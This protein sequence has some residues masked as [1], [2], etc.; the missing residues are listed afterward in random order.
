[1]EI[2]SMNRTPITIIVLGLAVVATWNLAQSVGR[3]PDGAASSTAGARI[4]VVDFVRVFNEAVQIRDLNEAIRQMTDD[5]TAEADQRRKA[6][7][8]KQLQLSAFKVG[9]ADYNSRR[10]ELFRLNI[11]ANVW[12]KVKEQEVEQIKYDW[13]RVIYTKALSIA[14]EL[15]TAQGYDAVLLRSEFKPDDLE[16]S[17]QALR[18]FIQDRTVIYSDARIDLSDTLIQKLDAE[19]NA[20]GGKQQL[21]SLGATTSPPAS[22]NAPADTPTP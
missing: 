11:E 10:D 18:R 4:A 13:T 14:E 6:I 19:Y 5:I 20:A 22:N 16:Q 2:G 15:A 8:N 17:V 3:Q 21:G 7:E 1:M 12:L 9:S